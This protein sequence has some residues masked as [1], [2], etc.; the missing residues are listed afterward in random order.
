MIPKESG[1]SRGHGQLFRGAKEWGGKTVKPFAS[2]R[3]AEQETCSLPLIRRWN[4]DALN[5][6]DASAGDMPFR[7]HGT[8][9]DPA[10]RRRACANDGFSRLFSPR[11]FKGKLPR[12]K[13][14]IFKDSNTKM[15]SVSAQA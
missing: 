11:E 13:G 14:L 3:A 1:R 10:R 6:A 8:A 4:I 5:T 15:P 12:K 2:L 9:V 7:S